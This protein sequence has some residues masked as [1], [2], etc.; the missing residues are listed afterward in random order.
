[1]TEKFDIVSVANGHHELFT[2]WSTL[3]QLGDIKDFKGHLLVWSR[4][5]E[6][7]LFHSP[8]LSYY[9]KA[10]DTIR[11]LSWVWHLILV[12][13]SDSF[14]HA[15]YVHSFILA[16]PLVEEISYP[17]YLVFDCLDDGWNQIG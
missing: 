10:E 7:P 5:L 1:M 17:R 4:A 15:Q 9:V 8:G 2:A 14:L 12:L 16:H 13:P 3:I 11:L 6:Q